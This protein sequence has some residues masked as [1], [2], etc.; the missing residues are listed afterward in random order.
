MG[1][2]PTLIVGDV[3]GDFER[4]EEALGAYSEDDMDTVF[5][6]DFFQGGRPGAGGGASAARIARHRRNSRWVLGNHDALLLCVL[7]LERGE[8]TAAAWRSRD[9]RPL[10]KV[11]LSRRGDPADLRAVGDDPGLEGWLRSLPLMLQL[12]DGTLVQH[13]DD[14]VYAGFAATVDQANEVLRGWMAA[15][16]GALRALRALIGRGGLLDRQRVDAYLSHWPATR[17]VHGHSP[18][19][20]DHPEVTHD[21]RVLGFDGRFSRY[22]T[23]APEEGTGPISATVALLPALGVG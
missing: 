9:G 14:D 12:E 11:W 18:H 1:V 17:V 23:R 7:D 20:H 15:P 19:W 10:D 6:G 5:L 8:T 4:L 3:Q 13:T 16:G 21:G 2:R 22:W